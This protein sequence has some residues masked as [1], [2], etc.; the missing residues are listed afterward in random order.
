MKL[1]F[2]LNG[3]DV[4]LNLDRD[5]S[6]TESLKVLLGRDNNIEEFVDEVGQVFS[7]Y[8]GYCYNSLLPVDK[9]VHKKT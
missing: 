2:K 4:T 5:H 6:V 1:Q 8:C 7:F 3:S 9:V